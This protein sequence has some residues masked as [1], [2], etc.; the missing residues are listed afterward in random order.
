LPV[1][2]SPPPALPLQKG[3]YRAVI[4]VV[5]DRAFTFY[6]PEN[7]EALENAGAQ[8]VFINALQDPILPQVDALYIGGGFPEMFLDELMANERL[9]QAIRTAVEDGLP[10]YAECG[11]LMYLAQRIHWGGRS[12][13]M[14]GALPLEVEDSARPQGH[15][16]V[17][18]LVVAPNPFLPVGTV[19]R[20][21][22]FHHSHVTNPETLTTNA[23]RL[24]RG[25]GLGGGQ[26]GLVYN[27]VLAAYTHLHA[28]GSPGWAEGLVKRARQYAQEQ[29]HG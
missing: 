4:G 15:G 3:V 1:A 23:Y 13:E 22:E 2:P 19:L 17:Q 28:D 10:V 16:Y 21:H 25:A 11:G 5:R 26:D 29:G 8:L 20:G 9:R 27:N 12:A 24:E 7:L 14:V 6:Y 18:A